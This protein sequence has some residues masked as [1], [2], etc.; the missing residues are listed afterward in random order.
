MAVKGVQRPPTSAVAE[1]SATAQQASQ[2]QEQAAKSSIAKSSQSLSS[3]VASE[4]VQTTVRSFRTAGAP[5]KIRELSK[6]KAL[7]ED[8]AERIANE[9]EGADAHQ[10]TPHTV[11]GHLTK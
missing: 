3:K 1:R 6:A 5:E 2:N 9:G 10:V 8:V 11:R 4:A 7:A